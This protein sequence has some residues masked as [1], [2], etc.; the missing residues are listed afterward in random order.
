MLI[1]GV[2]GKLV[3]FLRTSKRY[4]PVIALTKR[5]VYQGPKNFR[6]L[7]PMYVKGHEV[8]STFS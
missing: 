4:M 3:S 6:I 2:V 5:G 7:L 1:K 8:R